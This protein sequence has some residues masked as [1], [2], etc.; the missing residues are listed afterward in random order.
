[1]DEHLKLLAE[2]YYAV[3]RHLQSQGEYYIRMANTL[4]HIA[5]AMCENKE[6]SFIPE[7]HAHSAEGNPK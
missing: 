7:N 6:A 2:S 4:G 1:M 3:A 5:D